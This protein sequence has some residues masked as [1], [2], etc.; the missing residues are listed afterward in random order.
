MFD[1]QKIMRW[2]LL[3]VLSAGGA[4][5]EHTVSEPVRISGRTGESA[6]GNPV[7]YWP[8]ASLDARFE[9]TSLG[10][11][12]KDNSGKNF[13]QLIIDAAAPVRLDMTSGVQTY[14]VA[15]NLT[16]TVHDVQL[17]RITEGDL[18]A[19]EFLGF[20]L[21]DGKTLQTA[22]VGPDL[23]IEFYGDSIS[24]GLG[25]EATDTDSDLNPT[26]ENNYLAYSALTARNLNADYRCIAYSGIGVFV[27]WFPLIMPDIWDRLT[28]S[29]SADLWDFSR[30]TADVVVV[31]LFQ[32]DRWLY[33]DPTYWSD[34]V[35][36]EEQIVQKYVDF[37]SGI[38]T[39]YPDAHIVCALG[40]MDA[41][42]EGTPWPGYI[43]QA[44][45]NMAD[46]N[47]SECIF[48]YDGTGKHPRVSHHLDMAHQLT[49]HLRVV[50]EMEADTVILQ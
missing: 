20:V 40:S 11:T 50:L 5:A 17:F 36:T 42:K 27:S 43:H 28:P 1:K 31:N 47:M 4:L 35:L 46:D 2:G 38:R 16:D 18:G 45:V 9:G 13:Y 15:S 48:P 24:C 30:W 26:F 41:A 34:P 22:P 3:L 12:L 49:A 32:N 8:G 6:G 19:T 14:A 10:V 7:L 29:A 23:R 33:D 44:V 25:I 37:V 21:D 39:V